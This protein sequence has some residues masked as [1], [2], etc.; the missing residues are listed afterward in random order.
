MIQNTNKNIFTA[1]TEGKY[2]LNKL[3]SFISTRFTRRNISGRKIILRTLDKT[4]I[5]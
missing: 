4:K 2:C 3:H 5:N 1:E